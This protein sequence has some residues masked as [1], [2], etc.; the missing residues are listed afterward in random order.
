[1]KEQRLSKSW[2]LSLSEAHNGE[3]HMA[4]VD[5]AFTWLEE[6]VSRIMVVIVQDRNKQYACRHQ[7][8]GQCTCSYILNTAD[9]FDN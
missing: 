5:K 1:M 7:F 8:H 6:A 3:M 9:G 2:T 4:V